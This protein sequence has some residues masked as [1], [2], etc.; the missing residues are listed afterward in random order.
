MTKKEI[1]K[2]QIKHKAMMDAT[3]PDKWIYFD[4]DDTLVMWEGDVK[5]PGKGKVKI[6]LLNRVYYLTPNEKNIKTLLDCY[7]S[8]HM[9]VVWSL[10]GRAWAEKVINTLGL[11][12]RVHY[13][14]TKPT[15][16]V[17][18]RPNTYILKKSKN[19]YKK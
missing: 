15:F 7:E 2:L 14:L 18:D 1:K 19:L 3:H 4:V 12:W 17:D 16:Y 11:F 8:N 6:E 13:I 9:I 5:R 10:G